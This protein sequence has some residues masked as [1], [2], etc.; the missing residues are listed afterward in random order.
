M[1]IRIALG[2][3]LLAA[4][5]AGQTQYSVSWSTVAGGGGAS[6]SAPTVALVGSTVGQAAAVR[7]PAVPGG[8]GLHAG[9]WTGAPGMLIVDGTV[10]ASDDFT[11]PNGSAADQE[12][13]TGNWVSRWIGFGFSVTEGALDG[14]STMPVNFN[15]LRRYF[16]NEEK[17]PQIFVSFDLTTPASIE[18]DDFAVASLITVEF[19]LPPS[20]AFGKWPG[21]NE[22]VLGANQAPTGILILPSTTYHLVGAYDIEHHSWSLWINPDAND[23]Y[24]PAT[25]QGSADASLPNVATIPPAYMLSLESSKPGYVFDNL[26]LSH[27]PGGVGLASTP[28]TAPSAADLAPEIHLDHFTLVLSWKDLQVPVV[29]EESLDLQTWMPVDPQPAQSPYRAPVSTN[30]RYLRLSLGPR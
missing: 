22:F 8:V 26:V 16:R 11:Y 14:R 4:R 15:R 30:G 21:S 24:H 3:A 7:V 29:V 28:P 6:P 13:G 23:T 27:G 1:L 10:I 9:F 18:I 12:G 25:G 17:S 20:V 2:S 19:S 5:L